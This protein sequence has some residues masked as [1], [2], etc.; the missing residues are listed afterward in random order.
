M[1]DQTPDDLN[2]GIPAPDFLQLLLN[3]Q[4]QLRNSADSDPENPISE[5]APA[6]SAPVLQPTPTP[7]FSNAS[8]GEAPLVSWADQRQALF[9]ALDAALEQHINEAQR[10][11]AEFKRQVEEDTARASQGILADQDNLRQELNDLQQERATLQEQVAEVRQFIQQE[12]VRWNQA[13]TEQEA[14]EGELVSLR[15]QLATNRPAAT[16]AEAEKAPEPASAV[17]AAPAVSSEQVAGAVAFGDAETPKIP[18]GSPVIAAAEPAVSLPVILPARPV[19]PAE[20]VL[21][22]PVDFAGLGIFDPGPELE[23]IR[24]GPIHAITSQTF[25]YLQELLLGDPPDLP[26]VEATPPP[27]AEEPALPPVAERPRTETTGQLQLGGPTNLEQ[28]SGLPPRRGTTDQLGPRLPRRRH[29]TGRLGVTPAPEDE[30]SGI[31]PPPGVPVPAPVSEPEPVP[32][33]VTPRPRRTQPLTESEKQEKVVLREL[34]LQLGLTDP[35]TPPALN[36]MSF[37]AGYTPPRGALSLADMLDELHANVSAILPPLPPVEPA[38]SG[39]RPVKK[40]VEPPPPISPDTNLDDYSIE[41]E[42]PSPTLQEL[43]EAGEQELAAIN[44]DPTPPENPTPFIGKI[45]A[46]HPVHF[47]P[48]PTITPKPEPLAM[49]NQELS[50]EG[51]VTEP[52]KSQPPVPEAPAVPAAPPAPPARTFRPLNIRPLRVRETPE[53]RLPLTLEYSPWTG[54]AGT[55]QTYVTITNLQG[56]YTLPMLENILRR[57]TGITRLVITEYNQQ[58]LLGEVIHQADL[59]LA[60]QFTALPELPLRL[61]SESPGALLFV[62][63]SQ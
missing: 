31:T 41:E 20:P 11:V 49:L 2:K 60:A 35:R 53:T 16:V 50:V 9:A 26:G 59:N 47:Q 14:L 23:A 42:P 22:T 10:I 45:G 39:G 52:L 15:A 37:A 44:E 30:S 40:V 12:E 46:D 43:L 28:T 32:E 21:P 18:G 29:T 33:V 54:P 56:R 51:P 63:N 19:A 36:S 61:V 34:G 27:V 57:L 5:E 13:L 48:G 25:A 55:R 58:T 3:H 24:Q 17:S 1:A 4:A 6:P 7:D 38:T 8:A 62:Q